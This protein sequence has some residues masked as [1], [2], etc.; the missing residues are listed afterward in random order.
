MRGYIS[1]CEVT[2]E[3]EYNLCRP[4]AQFFNGVFLRYAYRIWQQDWVES[5]LQILIWT[6]I[7]KK[8][9]SIDLLLNIWFVSLSK[10][11]SRAVI[12]DVVIL[13]PGVPHFGQDSWN[14]FILHSFNHRSKIFTWLGWNLCVRSLVGFLIVLCLFVM[15]LVRF[16]VFHYFR[17][18]GRIV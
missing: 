12:S 17:S 9:L 2:V 1:T 16:C 4:E 6:R 11:H 8:K 13:T 10:V 14:S 7:R 3:W 18:S 15:L 5:R